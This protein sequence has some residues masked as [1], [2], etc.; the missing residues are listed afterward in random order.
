MIYLLLLLITFP[1]EQIG[2]Y[3]WGES[4]KSIYQ[5]LKQS[6]IVNRKMIVEIE[7]SNIL[8]VE[9]FLNS[10]HFEKNQL[11]SFTTA[12]VLKTQDQSEIIDICKLQ[13]MD[14]IQ[15]FGPVHDIQNEGLIWSNQETTLK[16]YCTDS[17]PILDWSFTLWERYNKDVLVHTLVPFEYFDVKNP[18][19]KSITNPSRSR[20]KTK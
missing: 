19:I 7:K 10:W 20:T 8:E 16:M 17:G 12:A 5:E 6:F 11:V 2:D 3:Y 9:Y 18:A 1:V 15:K 4:Y 13:L 14:I